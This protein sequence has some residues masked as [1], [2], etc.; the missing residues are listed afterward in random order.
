[1]SG[2]RTLYKKPKN[3]FR[4]HPLLRLPSHRKIKIKGQGKK[5]PLQSQK[6]RPYK[7]KRSHKTDF[8][9]EGEFSPSSVSQGNPDSAQ[10]SELAHGGMEKS[11]FE[12]YKD[13]KLKNE[14]LKGTT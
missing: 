5:V 9:K 6:S 4:K 3:G 8:P 1:M 10:T 7:P 14:L 2:R 13:I 12:K 11:I